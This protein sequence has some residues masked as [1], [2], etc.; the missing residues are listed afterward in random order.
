M[1]AR[2]MLVPMSGWMNTR[3]IGMA[4][5]T[6]ARNTS[7]SVTSPFTDDRNAA[8]ITISASREKRDGLS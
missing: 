4:P 6:I 1:A 2:M 7:G 3:S 5:R 8:S